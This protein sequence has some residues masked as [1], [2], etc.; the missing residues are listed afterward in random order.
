MTTSGK[1][2]TE[3]RAQQA[4]E[5]KF[6]R[7]F[8][9]SPDYITINHWK[10]GRFVEVN[11]SFERLTGYAVIDVVG[12]TP[13][14]LAPLFDV[15]DLDTVVEALQRDGIVRDR[16]LTLRTRA[17]A[18]VQCICSISLIELDGVRHA[19]TIARDVTEE[20]RAQRALR[21][22][23]TLLRLSLSAA[24]MGTWSRN[25][26]DDTYVWSPEASAIF[27][28]RLEAMPRNEAEALD[29][30]HPED[31]ARLIAAAARADAGS[32]RYAATIRIRRPD[33]SGAWVEVRGQ[34]AVDSQ[35]RRMR[36][37]V[38]TD[39]SER[40][41][42]D[43][44]QRAS[45]EKFAR[46]FEALPVY[47]LIARLSDGRIAEVNSAF[48]QVTGWSRGEA[49]GRTTVELG[50]IEPET[51]AALRAE[52]ERHG[53]VR[54]FEIRLRRRNGEFIEVILDAVALDV[55]GEAHVAAIVRDVTGQKRAELEV[56]R[57][58][59]RLEQRV[60]ERT[61]EL[62]VA[63]R[64]LEA[65]SYSVAHDL[66]APLRA[67]IGFSTLLSDE[68]DT[69]IGAA[70]QQHLKRT[71]DAAERMSGMI[72]ALLGLSKLMRVE[73]HRSRVSLSDLARTIAAE[74]VAS[75]PQRSLRLVIEEHL[76]VDGDARLLRVLLENLLGNAWKY[77]SKK[78]GARVELGALPATGRMR[79][80][81]VRDDG[82]GFDPAYAGRL[83]GVFQRLHGAGEFP[84]H[85]VGLS[86]VKRV[87]ER[88][89]GRVWAESAPER[90][91]TF[92]FELPVPASS[93]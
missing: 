67:I 34:T 91:A 58:N 51:R 11:R 90:G 81:Y 26:D 73:L 10:T 65:F 19:I 62:E 31:R 43:L 6:R 71:I 27:G 20:R 88:H 60:A 25:L 13:R 63:N 44:E 2:G 85:G 72:E 17:G 4:L 32:G 74:L 16:E 37:G 69:T 84:G 54:G 53:A 5:Q 41:A 18:L 82:A 80:F 15:P 59:A 77:T 29:L 92:Y 23:D 21:E 50:L 89:G 12:R 83:F 8:E 35:G 36:Y 52:T 79:T 22:T 48:E 3:R 66:R 56:R 40:R 39:V 49:I 42:A 33:E 76:E 7:I 14:E 64:E 93:A 45:R 61:R 24:H 1:Q 68:D 28:R 86:T 55:G 78:T 47:A 38:I 87:V 70:G 75:A 46:L 57:L 30:V 9:E